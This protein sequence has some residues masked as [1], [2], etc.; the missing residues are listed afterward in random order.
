MS[1]LPVTEQN[2]AAG[3]KVKTQSTWYCWTG[4][5][6]TWLKNVNS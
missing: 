2:W 3:G 6:F 1:L 5:L 4:R